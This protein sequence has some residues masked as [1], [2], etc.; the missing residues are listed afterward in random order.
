MGASIRSMVRK[1]A[2]L[3]VYDEMMMRVKN[4]QK[5][6]IVRPDIALKGTKTRSHG[7]VVKAEGSRQIQTDPVYGMK[8]NKAT[9]GYYILKS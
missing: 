2:R 6:A 9:T 4:H 3:A 8:W 7:S 1:A 5:L